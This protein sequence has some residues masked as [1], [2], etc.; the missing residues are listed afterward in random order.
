MEISSEMT[1]ET[2]RH[3]ELPLL[4]YSSYQHLL[5]HRQHILRFCV[6][7]NINFIVYVVMVVLMPKKHIFIPPFIKDGMPETL[8]TNIS[9][10]KPF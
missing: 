4:K 2:L 5:F 6:F 1:V 10:T 7:L 8:G 9:S 3:R